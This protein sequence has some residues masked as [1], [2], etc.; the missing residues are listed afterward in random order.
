[1]QQSLVFVR[2]ENITW[3]SP[4]N[5][6]WDAHEKMRSISPLKSIYKAAPSRSKDNLNITRQFLKRIL[7]IQD[8]KWTDYVNELRYLNDEDASDEGFAVA[9][10]EWIYEIY[11]ILDEL[12]LELDEEECNALR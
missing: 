8:A 6:R 12:R 1:M 4:S 11:G 3:K 9:S 2:R 10:S 5:C 7:D